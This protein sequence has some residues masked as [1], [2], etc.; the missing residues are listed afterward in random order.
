MASPGLLGLD[1]GYA[2]H[3]A[4]LGDFPSVD[5]RHG[6]EQRPDQVLGAAVSG[7]GI[8]NPARLRL[9]ERNEFLHRL[10]QAEAWKQERTTLIYPLGSLSDPVRT[11]S[12]CKTARTMPAPR[13]DRLRGSYCGTLRK[14]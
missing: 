7:R 3:F 13:S 9:G 10:R 5:A 4:P 12:S 1:A 6:Q 14:Y 11:S 8:V 2:D